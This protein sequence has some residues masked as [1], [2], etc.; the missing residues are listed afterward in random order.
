[1]LP[2]TDA[3]PR[4][5]RIKSAITAAVSDDAYFRTRPGLPG[6]R[7]RQ[8]EFLTDVLHSPGRV[9]S[10]DA[11]RAHRERRELVLGTETLTLAELEA[12]SDVDRAI[13]NNIAY[14]RVGGHDEL[15]ED[16]DDVES[17]DPPITPPAESAKAQFGARSRGGRHRGGRR[18]LW[19]DTTGDTAVAL[20]LGLLPLPTAAT[21]WPTVEQASAALIE[22]LLSAGLTRRQATVL[23]STQA[24][25]TAA[26]IAEALHVARSTVAAH[27]SA[28]RKILKKKRRGLVKT[29]SWLPLIN[30]GTH[31]HSGEERSWHRSPSCDFQ[32]TPRFKPA[33]RSACNPYGG[34]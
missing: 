8:R 25:Y 6:S 34:C 7:E 3:P 19:T 9:I 21:W 27:L 4:R 16:P 15:D 22:R 29:P 26:E 11:A 1:V 2:P 13:L 14:G 18:K 31:E 24:G 32:T 20:A 10:P 23:L 17:F 28:A 33:T 30:G 5:W 12:L